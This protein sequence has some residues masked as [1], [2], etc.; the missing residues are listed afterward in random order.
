M[1]YLQELKKLGQLKKDGKL[2]EEEFQKKKEEILSQSSKTTK[3]KSKSKT[4]QE[5]ESWFSKTMKDSLSDR[6]DKVGK[7]VSVLH[8]GKDEWNKLKRDYKS[9][10]ITLT[11]F[12][13]LSRKLKNTSGTGRLLIN[14]I[15][16]Y[17]AE[18]S[19]QKNNARRI[20]ERRNEE[21]QWKGK[22][23]KSWRKHYGKDVP[24]LLKKYKG[25]LFSVPEI[26]KSVQCWGMGPGFIN[27]DAIPVLRNIL[28]ELDEKGE[29]LSQKK[30]NAFY[31]YVDE[32]ARLNREK[33][34]K[35]EKEKEKERINNLKPSIIN[36]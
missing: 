7:A 32:D 20:K 14:N 22:Q 31:Y 34:E 17:F 16:Q 28:K 33:R 10:K 13:K 19:I 5:K 25:Q 18:I 8:D 9:K 6:L 24:L 26:S 27:P 29:I 11:E 36:Y 30:G 1:N 15:N 2:T 12:R 3:N 21:T 35:K 23:E 4:G